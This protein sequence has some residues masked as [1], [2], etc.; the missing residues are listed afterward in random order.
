MSKEP[1][2]EH[3]EER[4]R[5]GFHEAWFSLYFLFVLIVSGATYPVLL[6]E[7]FGAGL[8]AGMVF[9]AFIALT[10]LGIVIYSGLKV[11]RELRKHGVYEK[12]RK[13]GKTVR[14]G[15]KERRDRKNSL[16]RSRPGR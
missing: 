7:G 6:G 5:R 14:E 8:A 11:D 10:V 16:P 4:K 3:K 9:V 13:N 2:E 12:V 15:L 1:N